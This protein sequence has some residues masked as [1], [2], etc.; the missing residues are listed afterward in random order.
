MRKTTVTVLS[1]VVAFS[2]CLAPKAQ[3]DLRVKSKYI[4]GGQSNETTVY[5]KGARQRF[6]PGMGMAI[7]NQND[8]N[9]TVQLFDDKKMFM[10]MSSDML[11]GA[12]VPGASQPQPAAPTSTAKGG[13]VNV[14]IAVTDSGETKQMFGYVARH[15]K[16]T[17]TT[18]AGADACNPGNETIETDGWYIDYMPDATPTSPTPASA[19]APDAPPACKDDVR[20]QQ[21]GNGVLGY[22]LAYTLKTTKDG[23]TT[24]L[25]ME[26][27]EFSPAPLD[28]ALFEVPADYTELKGFAGMAEMFAAAGAPPAAGA[29]ASSPAPAAAAQPAVASTATGFVTPKAPG[30]IRVGVAEIGNRAGRNL[31]PMSP[32]D[33]L[34]AELLK[35][36]VDA[37]PLAGS[38]VAEVEAAAKRLESDYIL[39]SEVTEVK[40]GGGGFG[41]LGAALNKAA[42]LTGGAAAK[43]KLEAKVEYRLM[44]IDGSK[45]LLSSS[46]KGTNGGGFGVTSAFGLAMNLTSFGMFSKMGMF[47]PNMMRLMGGGMGMGAGMGGT[48]MGALMG[49]PGMPRG[50]LDPGLSPFMAAM[51]ATQSAMTPPQ[52]TEDG[53]AVGDAFTDEAK[54]ISE[55]LRKKK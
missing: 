31:G 2:F 8:V 37:V 1:V 43:E 6:E 42:A 54:K 55:A 16:N 44:P 12:A 46:S 34:V 9:R 27:V 3:A 17:M 38:N 52:P 15:V 19:P 5:S 41:G 26:I 51:S 53:K 10:I 35:A 28:S 11:A 50:G 20:V 24:E 49:I 36:N 25:K 33:Q 14:T 32:R 29:S 45:A 7:I 21:S 22:P 30:A 23:K 4:A 18:Q 40:T 13:I 39:F 47:D 48:G